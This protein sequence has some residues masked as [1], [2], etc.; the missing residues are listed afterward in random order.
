MRPFE[1]KRVFAVGASPGAGPQEFVVRPFELRRALAAG[2]SF[3]ARAD[4]S[5]AG[6][7]SEKLLTDK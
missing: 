4:F 1:S 5:H 6:C 2:A 3:C 7:F